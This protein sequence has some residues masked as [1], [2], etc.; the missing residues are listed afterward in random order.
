MA[1]RLPSK[2]GSYDNAC[3]FNS[4]VPTIAH[5]MRSLNYRTITAGKMHF[6]GRDQLHGFEERLTTDIYPSDFNWVPDWEKPDVR[7][8]WYH[9]MLSVVQAGKCATSNQIEF[10]DEVTFYS[11]RR[12]LELGRP[13]DD[14]RPFFMTVSFTHPHDPYAIGE[15][16][17]NRYDHDSIDMPQVANIDPSVDD[18][19]SKRLRKAIALDEYEMSPER[20]RNARHAYYGAISY[21]DDS[22]G[23]L[24]KALEDAGLR[25]NTL[26][27]FTSDHGDML[28]ERGLWYKMNW[29]EM[30]ARIP[31]VINYPKK[32][33]P[34][35][36]ATHVSAIDLL[37]TFV[38]IAKNGLDEPL[39]TP[40]CG[41]SLYPILI[42]DDTKVKNETF[43]EYM[44][45]GAICPI[46][47]I[48]RNQYKFIYCKIDPPQLYDLSND[49]HELKN[50]ANQVGYESLTQ[51]FE[52][53][54]KA[55]WN[56]DEIFAQVILDQKRRRFI[57]NSLKKGTKDHWDF[58]PIRDASR[59]Y[60]RGHMDLDDIE[61]RARL[62]PVPIPKPDG[63]AS[64]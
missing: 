36:V 24:I 59:M 12:I 14:K 61:K 23:V 21:V 13:S 46:F 55:K 25:E 44:G 6:V 53:E 50:L 42:G 19:H 22:I 40:I 1:G 41:R 54:V 18:S 32:F 52:S 4:S 28:G 62:P 31:L 38:S 60:V 56:S 43:G 64:K 48:R 7:P 33:S 20:I 29:F 58:Q 10:D 35:R 45:E 51:D 15:E 2:I 26:I 3:E 34:R 11:K 37:P 49:P 63:R 9:N 47:F 39:E 27:V 57:M 17:W 5:Y 30:A 8:E 16:Y